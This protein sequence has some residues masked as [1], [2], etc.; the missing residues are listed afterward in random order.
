MLI[1]LRTHFAISRRLTLEKQSAPAIA[2]FFSELAQR[3]EA[4]FDQERIP[5]D[6]RVTARAVDLHYGGQGYELTIPCPDGAID[7]AA[8]AALENEFARQ[9]Q[10]QYGYVAKGEPVHLT[11]LRLEVIGRVPKADLRPAAQATAPVSSAVRGEREVWLPETNGFTR[12]PVYDRAHLGPGHRLTGPAI[13]EQMDSTT[14][15]L[16]GQKVAIDPFLN[17]IIEEA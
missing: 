7:A 8:I 16:P 6:S 5:Q 12:C 2:G 15:T 1:D 14:L 11:T 4:W 10:L 13:I 9:H 3:A 17:I